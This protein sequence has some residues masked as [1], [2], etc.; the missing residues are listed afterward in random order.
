MDRALPHTTEAERDILSIFEKQDS[1]T[2][3]D[4]ESHMKVGTATAVRMLRK[5]VEGNLIVPVGKGK[6]RIM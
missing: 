6:I 5:M 2:R 1:M 4:V 3:K